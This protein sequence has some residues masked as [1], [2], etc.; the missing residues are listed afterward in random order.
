MSSF[1]WKWLYCPFIHTNYG[2]SVT[3]SCNT[4]HFLSNEPLLVGR[5]RD[6]AAVVVGSIPLLWESFYGI[7]IISPTQMWTKYFFCDIMLSKIEMIRVSWVHARKLYS[8]EYIILLGCSYNR[9]ID[10]FHC[11]WSSI[12]ELGVIKG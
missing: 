6:A 7:Q 1:R 8:N 9:S 10:R 5:K 2:R 3:I 11:K 12:F 4:L